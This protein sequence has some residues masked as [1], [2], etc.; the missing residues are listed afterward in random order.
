MLGL[1]SE[2]SLL[3]ATIF[4]PIAAGLIYLPHPTEMA[5]VLRRL[6]LPER[7]WLAISAALALPE[8]DAQHLSDAL[9]ADIAAHRLSPH[10]L[11]ADRQSAAWAAH[12]ADPAR[13]MRR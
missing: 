1:I 5:F 10:Q 11:E 9:D 7:I 3:T 8:C 12:C 13:R 4:L 2:S 6:D